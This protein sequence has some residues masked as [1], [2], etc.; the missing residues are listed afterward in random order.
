MLSLVQIESSAAPSSTSS[1][2]DSAMNATARNTISNRS[3]HSANALASS[4]KRPYPAVPDTVTERHGDDEYDDNTNIDLMLQRKASTKAFDAADLEQSRPVTPIDEDGTAARPSHTRQNSTSSNG[5]GRLGTDDDEGGVEVLQ[6]MYYPRKNL[7]R[8]ASVALINLNGGL[9]DS[10]AGAVLPYIERHYD[11]G[12]GIVSLIFVATAVGSITAAIVV[13]P[14]KRRYGYSRTLL[15]SQLFMAAGY[16]PLLTMRAPFPAVVVGFF[17]VGLAEAINVAMGNTFCAGLQQGT[18]ALGV[19]HGSYGIGG[20]SGPL[21]ATAVAVASGAATDPNIK[22]AQSFGNYYFL[23]FGVCIAASVMVSWAFAGFEKEWGE[24]L[25][26]SSADDTQ[27]SADSGGRHRRWRVGRQKQDQT[28]A[29]PSQETSATDNIQLVDFSATPLRRPQPV[30]QPST[31]APSRA[32]SPTPFGASIASP[33]ATPSATMTRPIL[34][35][36]QS[37]MQSAFPTP[38]QSFMSTA[39]L[40]NSQAANPIDGVTTPMESGTSTPWATRPQAPS[41]AQSQSQVPQ[42][43]QAQ[44]RQ[45]AFTTPASIRPR[46][47]RIRR[48]KARVYEMF[49]APSA[50]VVLLGAMFLFMYQGSEVSI[51][52]WVT[53]FLIADRGGKEPAVGYV[54]AGFWAGITLGRFCLAVPAQKIGPR[55][56]VYGCVV[57]AGIFELLVWFVP[58][59]IGDAVAVSIVGLLLGP[60]YPCAADV[61][62]RNLSRKERIAGVSAMAAFGSAGGAAAPFI[63]GVLAQVAGTFVLHPIAIALFVGMLIFWFLIPEPKKPTE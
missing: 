61:L 9:S 30:S 54:T 16:V 60:V 27:P 19:M 62:M 6:S 42:Q 21:V 8:L 35:P 25:R 20:I 59:V 1:A 32:P 15:L 48:S 17:F 41:R 36:L 46:I 33:L 39:P 58:N 5:S 56:F 24:N 55:R 44:F 2:T 23:P 3:S 26:R 12:Y 34:S 43:Q 50:R 13:D 51:A 63:T 29:P 14:I 47:S 49:T 18:V 38:A 53:S 22:T 37:P 28:A 45:Q 40:M 7:Y 10:A 4:S 52:G 31:A 57:G 11:I